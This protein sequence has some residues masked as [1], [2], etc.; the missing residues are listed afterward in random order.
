MVFF[1]R[2]ISRWTEQESDF[3]SVEMFW[4]EEIYAGR[5]K[6]KC[7]PV[8]INLRK[9]KAKFKLKRSFDIFHYKS[10]LHRCYYDVIH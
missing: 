7:S 6:A 8:A 4:E 2:I 3:F 10:E 1:V 5:G 9:D